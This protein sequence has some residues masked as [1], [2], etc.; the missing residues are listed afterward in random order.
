MTTGLT[1]IS[2]ELLLVMGYELCIRSCY[3]LRIMGFGLGVVGYELLG[4]GLWVRS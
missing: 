2:Y 4:C 3:E 1:A